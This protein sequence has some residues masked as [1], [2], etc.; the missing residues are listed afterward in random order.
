MYENDAEGEPVFGSVA[1]LRAAV[2]NGADIRISSEFDRTP[3]ASSYITSVQNTQIIDGIVCAQALFH[4]SRNG[5]DRFQV[6][7]F[8]YALHII[9]S[10][11]SFNNCRTH[12]CIYFPEMRVVLWVPRFCYILKYES[13]EG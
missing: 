7:M 3:S 5:Y 9:T 13:V 6:K 11:L 2:L 4:V 10:E 12:V 1:D 8:T